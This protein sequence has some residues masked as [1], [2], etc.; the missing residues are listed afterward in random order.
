METFLQPSDF[1]GVSFWLV[2][3]AMVASSVFFFY[4]GMFGKASW[5]TSMVVAGLI[6]LIAAVH[7][8]Y[9]REY[10]VHVNESPIIYRYI[11]WLL[12]VPLQMIEFYLILVAASAVISGSVFWRLLIGTFIMLIGGYSGEIGWIDASL[13]FVIGMLGW[14]IIIWEIF[15]GEASVAASNNIA[16]KQAFNALRLIVLVGWAIYPIGYIFGILTPMIGMGTINDNTLNIIYNLAD[17]INKIL[18]GLIIWRVAVKES[19][20]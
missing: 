4:E 5:R 10:W 12:T 16:V 15:R 7:Y 17:F 13:G 6:T 19:R 14:A 11:D 3:I 8:Y 20:Q 9:M 1:V 18:F 2:S